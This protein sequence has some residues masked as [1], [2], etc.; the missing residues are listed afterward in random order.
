MSKTNPFTEEGTCVHCECYKDN[1]CTQSAHCAIHEDPVT[2]DT[3][4]DDEEVQCVDCKRTVCLYSEEIY[5]RYDHDTLRTLWIC[6]RCVRKG[7][8][9][10]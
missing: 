7:L 8:K 2:S 3:E 10:D 4:V 9:N 5:H 1:E 6:N